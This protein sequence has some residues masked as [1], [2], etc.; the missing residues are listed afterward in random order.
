MD[1]IREAAHASGLEVVN[2]SGAMARDPRRALEVMLAVARARPTAIVAAEVS[3]GAALVAHC[4]CDA[5][6]GSSGATRTGPVG[7]S[8]A[9]AARPTR[10]RTRSA[11]KRG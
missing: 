10:P 1:A 7:S 6:S 8:R 2:S 3:G 4:A 5:P 11:S 9:P